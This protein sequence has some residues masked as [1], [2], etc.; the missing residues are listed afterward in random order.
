MKNKEEKATSKFLYGFGGFMFFLGLFV[1]VEQATACGWG[2]ET[3]GD[4][5]IEVI[6]VEYNEKDSSP[7]S[8][9]TKSEDPKYQKKMGDRYRTGDG[10]QEDLKEALKWYRMAASQDYA[11]A[12]NNLA[13]MYEKGLGLS[14][15]DELAAQWFGLA[16]KKGNEKAQHS[17]GL[18]YLEGRGVQQDEKKAAEWLLMSAQNGHYSAMNDIAALKFEGRGIE[19]DL[20]SA[21]KWWKLAAMHGYDRA[22]QQLN[23]AKLTLSKQDI[24]LAEQ[25][26]SK[27]YISKKKLTLSGLY[28]T[29]KA[30]YKKL[31]E[32][33]GNYRLIDV[34]TPGEYIYVGHPSM[35]IN[36]PLRF[37]N[38]EW[39]TDDRK[40]RMTLNPDFV[41]KVKNKFRMADTIFV[42]CRSGG[43]SAQA[44]NQLVDAGFSKVYNIIDGFE[45]DLLKDPTNPDNGKRVVN[46]WKNAG[47]PW[48]YELNLMQ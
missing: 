18:M 40:P 43:R 11:P 2:G 39:Q 25:P 4:E 45:G 29:A 23:R 10:R 24:T 47:A 48:T 12:Q 16:A 7:C 30:A 22:E 13:A 28:I 31:N 17:L 14:K 37:L 34:R 1:Q 19:K 3:E 36:I 8:Q 33:P 41:E 26:F 46:G 42:I 6:E 35:A 9:K 32:N 27:D 21:Y 15:S 20:I 44:I 38:N 5:D